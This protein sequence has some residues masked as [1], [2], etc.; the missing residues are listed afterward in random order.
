MPRGLLKA[1]TPPQ[2]PTS[3]SRWVARLPDV[4]RL[5]VLPLLRP[6]SAVGT[7]NWSGVTRLGGGGG[8]TGQPTSGAWVGRSIWP[9]ARQKRLGAGPDPRT[10]P[11]A[12]RG[13]SKVEI[14]CRRMSLVGRARLGG[15]GVL[16]PPG[17]LPAGMPC[18]SSVWMAPRG[19]VGTKASPGA[20][21]ATG[22]VAHG[23]APPCCP[24]PLLPPCRRR[25]EPCHPPPM[26]CGGR[27]R[28]CRACSTSSACS[29]RLRP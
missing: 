28:L 29:S 5:P 23:S 15:A 14:A 3:C 19:S 7:F 1:H 11:G 25:R 26:S 4:G 22:H 10:A 12:V 24:A 20:T 18:W 13:G 17:P 9:G 21:H 27:R 2:A 6:A 8:P 16:G